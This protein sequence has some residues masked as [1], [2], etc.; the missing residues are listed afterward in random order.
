MNRPREEKVGWRETRRLIGLDMDMFGEWPLAFGAFSRKRPRW[1]LFLYLLT[2]SHM[3]PSVL[4]Y[5]LQILLFDARL[6]PLATM[7]GRM[8]HILF[9]VTIGHHVRTTGGLYIAH[10]HA[11][12]D[13]VIRLGHNVQ[14]AP[15]VTLG[16]TNSEG[17]SFDLIGPTIGDHVNIGTGAKVLGPV[18]I[19]DHVKIGANAV[20]VHDVPAGH[21]AV[22]APARS[23]PTVK[24]EER[25]GKIEIVDAA[26]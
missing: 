18:T 23:F 12:F 26:I 11:V 15:F 20:V 10:G 24:R 25:E 13:G 21:T 22:G 9:G 2:T 17:H 8:N 1:M 16:L 6:A 14:I 3:F 7:L 19:G 5:R 4:L